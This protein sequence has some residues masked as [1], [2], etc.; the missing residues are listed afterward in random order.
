MRGEMALK[1]PKMRGGIDR[2]RFKEMCE[3]TAK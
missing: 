1:E 3:E 2:A